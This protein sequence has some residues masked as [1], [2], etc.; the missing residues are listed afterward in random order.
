MTT[1]NKLV[2]DK[3]PHMI[4]A[5]GQVCETR[6]LNP[7]EYKEALTAKLREETDEYFNAS[8]DQEALDELADILE[9][10]RAL[11]DV[12][13]SSWPALE[14]LRADKAQDRGAFEDRVFLMDVTKEAE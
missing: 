13:G 12:R 1:Y 2:R 9:V 7:E 6:I 3:I 11:A 14:E 5:N 10:I 8:T 4:S